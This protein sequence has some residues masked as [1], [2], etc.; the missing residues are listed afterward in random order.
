MLNSQNN[1]F[2]SN[3]QKDAPRKSN[4]RNTNVECRKSGLRK[5]P[6]EN[7]RNLQQKQGAEM[8]GAEIVK[9]A[10]GKNFRGSRHF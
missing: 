4:V 2:S 5:H 1:A 3:S 8:L 6:N 9:S 7:L 10:A